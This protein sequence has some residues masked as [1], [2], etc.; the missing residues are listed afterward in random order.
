[1]EVERPKVKRGR[2][3]PSREEIEEHLATAHAV[4]RSWCGH[5]V[6]AR[7]TLHR[8][9]SNKDP[10]EEEGALPT[11]AID[12]FWYSEEKKDTANLHVKDNKSKHVW[13]S[14]VPQKGVDDYAVNFLIN[15]L[16]ETGYQRLV[17]KSDNENSI[18]ALKEKVKAEV[19]GIE[20]ILNDGPTGDKQANGL[21]EVAVR[22]TKRQS[23]ALFSELEER[24]GKI[25]PSHPLLLWLSR[26]ATFCLSRFKIGDDGKTPY[27]RLTGRKW[28]RPMV[29]FGERV[30]FRPLTARA[31][32]LKP[33]CLRAYTC[34]PM[35]GTQMCSA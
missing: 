30:W 26:H 18:K 4:H 14:A 13:A 2:K 16:K 22:E 8:H 7:A 11:I 10:E 21:A 20:V 29:Q 33:K 15:C 23:R 34:A 19:Q 1:M 12:C 6:R 28:K 5:C 3:D 31:E 9:G 35:E 24:L 32:T 27:T 25:E 17:L